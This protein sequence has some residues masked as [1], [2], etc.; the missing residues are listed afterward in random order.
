M[1]ERVTSTSVEF[2]HAFH[3][4]GIEGQYPAGT[5]E[6]QTIEEQIEG[7]SFVAYRRLSTTIALGSA[8]S[9]MRS[10]QI[11]NIDPEDLHDAL[12][13]DREVAIG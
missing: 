5:Y 3:L 13:K 11:S 7:L 1:T 4:P 8:I 12:T 10:I 9:G 2:R 6:V